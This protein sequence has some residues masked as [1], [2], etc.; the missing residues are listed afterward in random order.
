M[1]SAHL[2]RRGLY[3]A[4]MHRLLIPGGSPLVSQ[5]SPSSGA[6]ATNELAAVTSRPSRRCTRDVTRPAG[7]SANGEERCPK[8]EGAERI[9]RRRG[10]TRAQPRTRKRLQDGDEPCL[11]G[12]VTMYL[13]SLCQ[14]HLTAVRVAPVQCKGCYPPLYQRAAYIPTRRSLPA[15]E[16]FVHGAMYG[17]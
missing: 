12:S 8:T 14:Y 15:L 17:A 11:L 2:L 10:S 13:P 7:C 16:Q 4:T 5:L 1:H 9:S 3:A 6:A